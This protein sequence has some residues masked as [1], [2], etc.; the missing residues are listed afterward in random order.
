MYRGGSLDQGTAIGKTRQTIEDN[1]KHVSSFS[2]A[3]LKTFKS[4]SLFDRDNMN[5]SLMAWH[6]ID[7]ADLKR[8]V[9]HPIE[10]IKTEEHR[11]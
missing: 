4:I 5:I 2:I 8:N 11:R 3:F 1:K 6:S 9:R 7:T 10:Y